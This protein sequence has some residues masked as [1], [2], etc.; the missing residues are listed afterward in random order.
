MSIDWKD[1]RKSLHFLVQMDK[2]FQFFEA[3]DI[4]GEE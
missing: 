2:R 1:I 3:V 4:W